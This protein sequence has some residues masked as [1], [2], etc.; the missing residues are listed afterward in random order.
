M[1]IEEYGVPIRIDQNEAR[2][3]LRFLVRFG[4]KLDALILQPSLDLPNIGERGQLLCILVPARIEGEDVLFE[5][6]LKKPDDVV[7]VLHNQPV[8]RLISRERLEAQVSV[9]LPRGSD[10]LDRQAD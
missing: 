9:E 5:H 10:V 3:A 1:L 6:T 7:P 2:R 8:L 4:L